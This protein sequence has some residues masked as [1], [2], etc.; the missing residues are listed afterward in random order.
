[1]KPETRQNK[2]LSGSRLTLTIICVCIVYIISGKLGLSFASINPS[3]SAIW[4]PTA[5]A[6][7]SFL[8]FG[9]GIWPAIFVG[10]FLVNV[11][12]TSTIL[13]SIFI[14][15]GNTLEGAIG[16]YFLNKFAGGKKVFEKM[17]YFYRFV[18]YA[19]LLST[20]VS[21]TIGVTTL[22]LAHLAQWK[23]Y[24]QIWTTWWLGDAMGALIF[25]PIILLWAVSY[26]LK[27]AP[28]KILEFSVLAV[29]MI[30]ITQL[31]LMHSFSFLYLIIPILIWLVLRFDPKETASFIAIFSLISTF[32]T[33]A[34]VGPFASYTKN[35]SLLFTQTFIGVIS[36]SIL[37]LSIFIYEQKRIKWKRDQVAL[38]VESNDQ[39]VIAKTL[40]GII[41]FWNTGAEKLYGYKAEEIIGKH[42]SVITHPDRIR[43]FS[44]I[45]ENI[46]E[47]IKTESIETVRVRKD[48]S[49]IDVLLSNSP[50]ID[51]DGNIIGFSTITTDITMRKKLELIT[52]NENIKLLEAE[53]K[54]FLANAS[55]ELRTPLAIIKGN[56]EVAT[57][58]KNLNDPLGVINSEV[59]HLS[60]IIANLIAMSDKN[61]LNEKKDYTKIVIA[62]LMHDVVEN[63][64]PFID[65]K[66][67]S[68]DLHTLPRIT[69]LGNKENLNKLFNNII[70]NAITHGGNDKI[71]ISIKGKLAGHMVQI[72]IS[73]DGSGIPKKDLTLIFKEFYR[74]DQARATTTGKGGLG[75][76]VVKSIAE[77][78]GGTVTAES[79]INEGST[80]TV[81]LPFS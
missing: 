29:V 80:F 38:I 1:M 65:K 30:F 68:I 76:S 81:S 40:Q 64:R 31:I 19:V 43:E 63:F 7:A 20:L 48:G 78:H 11:T 39:A 54:E 67:I 79:T 10:A 13:S 8:L 32:D 34:G 37:P 17:H 75:L 56:I 53:K 72:S 41:T 49:Y 4:I 33:N 42:I 36:L 59:G 57:K 15:L 35:E 24:E 12:T 25:T 22:T 9:Y 2:M 71:K 16:A 55:H 66:N 28:K 27:L 77:A 50:I 69:V 52:E 26:K 74:S 14:A 44:Q 70:D 61:T 47:G 6:L 60:S 18:I 73:D 51:E 58:S 46:K 45:L 5:V 21:A 62:D 3:S 23:D